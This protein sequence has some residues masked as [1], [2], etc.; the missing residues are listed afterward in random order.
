MD[1]QPLFGEE[2]Q[3]TKIIQWVVL[4]VTGVF[5]IYCLAI[6]LTFAIVDSTCTLVVVGAWLCVNGNSLQKFGSTLPL[7]SSSSLYFCFAVSAISFTVEPTKK[8]VVKSESSQIL[9]LS[10]I[11]VCS[12]PV[13]EQPN[14]SGS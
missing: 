14:S 3:T 8:K 9:T 13:F 2:K 5:L 7:P 1:G 12:L 4:G 11:V 10:L 6:A